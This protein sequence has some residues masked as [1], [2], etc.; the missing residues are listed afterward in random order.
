MK[1]LAVALRSRGIEG[2]LIVRQVILLS[3]HVDLHGSVTPP[4]LSL[5]L[6]G[7]QSASDK[8][9]IIGVLQVE[10]HHRCEQRRLAAS[11]VINPSTI[12][13]V[14]ISSVRLEKKQD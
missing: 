14:T 7:G 3:S 5:L 11:G 2:G 8:P 13:Y 9:P 4:E 10:L 12:R 6:Q 1:I